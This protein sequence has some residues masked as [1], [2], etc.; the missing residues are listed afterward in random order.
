[1]SFIDQFLSTGSKTGQNWFANF[2]M[3]QDHV[4]LVTE[5]PTP[6]LHNGFQINRGRYNMKALKSNIIF[7]LAGLLVFTLMVSSVPVS[8]GH[9]KMLVELA[10]SATLVR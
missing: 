3:R 1:M 5:R 4:R 10:S 9:N 7:L 2:N 8:N 6:S